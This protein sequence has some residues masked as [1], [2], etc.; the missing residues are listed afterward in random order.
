[1]VKSNVPQGTYDI[2]AEA[3]GG[4]LEGYITALAQA[5][6]DHVVSNPTLIAKVDELHHRTVEADTQF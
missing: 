5:I 4:L 1:M 3:H 2:N 6:E